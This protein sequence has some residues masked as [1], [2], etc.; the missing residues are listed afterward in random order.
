MIYSVDNNRIYIVIK[1]YSKFRL[2]SVVSPLQI[3]AMS[4]AHAAQK[5]LKLGTEAGF[6]ATFL[7]KREA[8]HVEV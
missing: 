5:H 1:Q 4:P 8:G 6:Q 2:I 3:Y 7:V